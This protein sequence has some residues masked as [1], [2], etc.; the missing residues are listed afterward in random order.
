MYNALYMKNSTAK[1]ILG[2]LVLIVMGGLA[3]NYL[4]APG[5]E[6]NGVSSVSEMTPISDLDWQK[7]GDSGVVLTEYADFQCPACAAFHP[8]VKQLEAEY[9]GRVTFVYRHF[10]LAM[11][12]NAVPASLAAEAAG[13]QGKFFE[14]SSM[15]FEN[16]QEWETSSN[17]NEIFVKY[18]AELGLDI[19]KFNQDVVRDDLRQKIVDSYKDGI[20]SKVNATPTFF[21]NGVKIE[22]PR[23][24]T[25]EDVTN[26]FKSLIDSAIKEKE[27]TITKTELDVSVSSENIAQ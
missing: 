21:L 13:A 16:Q 7:K 18:V 23:G 9:A 14:M 19:D 4:K 15:L 10:P 6:T 12:I 2:A 24:T 3:F 25:I 20:K 11:H 22:T 27:G 8:I 1:L 26:G 5:T 17:P